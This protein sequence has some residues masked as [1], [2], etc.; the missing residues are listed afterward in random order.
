MAKKITEKRLYNIALYYLSRYETTSEKLKS[1]LKRRLEKARFSGDEV[2]PLA[3]EWIE[4]VV[5]DMQRQGYVDDNRFASNSI[6]RWFL[7][8]KSLKYIQGKLRQAGLSSQ[9]LSDF[10]KTSEKDL[11]EWERQAAETFVRKKKMGYFRSEEQ[12][13]E[14]YAKDL[15]SMARAGFPLD[16]AKESLKT[17]SDDEFI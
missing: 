10:E 13:K 8:G 15:A 4:K 14:R 1:V 9:V 2:N 5:S 11:R 16:V 12:Q 3:E 17:A 7:S 6:E